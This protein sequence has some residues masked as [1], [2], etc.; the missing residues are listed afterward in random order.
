MS[1]VAIPY[2]HREKTIPSWLCV[3]VCS[4]VIRIF[5]EINHVGD[6]IFTSKHEIILEKYFNVFEKWNTLWKYLNTNT[7]FVASS[8]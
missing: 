3:C 4:S 1:L 6:K 5:P 7:F 8:N 2:D